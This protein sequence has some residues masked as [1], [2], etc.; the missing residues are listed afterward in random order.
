MSAPAIITITATTGISFRSRL[1]LGLSPPWANSR[2]RMK[3]PVKNVFAAWPEGN[4]WPP[5]FSTSMLWCG[6]VR[7]RPNLVA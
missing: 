1:M 7:P 2:Q 5:A 4:A 3:K 6:P